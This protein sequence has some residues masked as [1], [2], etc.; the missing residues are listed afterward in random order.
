MNRPCVKRHPELAP[1][2]CRTC[3]LFLNDERYRKLWAGEPG[4]LEKAAN[5]ASA[6]VSHAQSGFQ[7]LP[8]G[9]V[10]DRLRV[11]G[12]CEQNNGGRC[13]ACGCHVSL[14][15]GWASQDCPLRKWPCISLERDSQRGSERGS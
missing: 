2:H 10:E 1:D 9:I 4:L 13:A 14:K 5:F 3:W 11:C 8:L 7:K 12:G 15:A 6:L